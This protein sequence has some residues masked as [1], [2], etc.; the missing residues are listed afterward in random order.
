MVASCVVNNCCWFKLSLNFSYSNRIQFHVGVYKRR[1]HR[2]HNASGW[3]PRSM[4]VVRHHVNVVQVPTINYVR[5]VII[6]YLFLL[7]LDHLWNIVGNFHW[8]N[9]RRHG[10]S[11]QQALGLELLTQL[12]AKQGKVL[13]GSNEQWKYQI[14]YTKILKL[15]YPVGWS[16]HAA[17]G[18]PSPSR[19]R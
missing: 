3:F 13:L 19:V 14:F 2:G 8:G 16:Y 17:L 12:F 4:V 10:C 9:S 15:P 1:E 18:I 11:Q 6:I 7:L 5:L